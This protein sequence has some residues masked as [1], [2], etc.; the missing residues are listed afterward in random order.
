MLP[1]KGTVKYIWSLNTDIFDMNKNKN[2]NFLSNTNRG[3]TRG[4][5]ITVIEMHCEGK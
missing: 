2:K 5:V 4:K 3:P 1:S